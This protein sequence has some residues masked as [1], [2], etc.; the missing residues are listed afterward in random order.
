MWKGRKPFYQENKVERWFYKNVE[1]AILTWPLIPPYLE[2]EGKTEKSI[3]NAIK[4][5]KIKGDEIGNTNLVEI[6]KEYGH[7]GK[8]AGDFCGSK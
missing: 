7:K 2:L 3:R 5:L 6:F 4:T 1:I 8:D